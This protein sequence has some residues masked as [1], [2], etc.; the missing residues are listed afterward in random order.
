M[1]NVAELYQRRWLNLP[2]MDVLRTTPMPQLNTSEV[3]NGSMSF[4][5]DT[6]ASR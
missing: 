2:S 1:P 4:S 5:A 3:V 6:Y